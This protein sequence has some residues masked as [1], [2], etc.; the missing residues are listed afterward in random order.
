MKHLYLHP[1]RF[2]STNIARESFPCTVHVQSQLE[3]NM[4]EIQN[5]NQYCDIELR[6]K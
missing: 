6:S 3:A 1:K 2:Q 5:E 4:A